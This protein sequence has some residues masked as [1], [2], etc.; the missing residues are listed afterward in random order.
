[1]NHKRG[2]TLYILIWLFLS[3]T[4]L[5]VE[6]LIEPN[7]VTWM[8]SK[9]KVMHMVVPPWIPSLCCFPLCG[10]PEAGPQSASS[11][12]FS[13]LF[14]PV[15]AIWITSGKIQVS[16]ETPHLTLNINHIIQP[17]LPESSSGRRP[18]TS[19]DNRVVS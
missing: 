3:P 6:C 2:V 1:M 19:S 9:S 15:F 5:R 12:A 13:Y 10:D 8:G 4:P 18:L 16:E 7:S 14:A 11:L 17:N